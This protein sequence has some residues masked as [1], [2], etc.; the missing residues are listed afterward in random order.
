ML[1][2]IIQATY[3][4]V[5]EGTATI[6]ISPTSSVVTQTLPGASSSSSGTKVS[7]GTASTG[8]PTSTGGA[9]TLSTGGHAVALAFLGFFLCINF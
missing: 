5:E 2:L 9:V 4:T 7:T 6:S 1:T 3:F 8:S